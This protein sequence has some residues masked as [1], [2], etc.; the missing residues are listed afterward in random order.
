M[1]MSTRGRRLPR[2]GLALADLSTDLWVARSVPPFLLSP[3]LVVVSDCHLRIFVRRCMEV[4]YMSVKG[5][6]G[7]RLATGHRRPAFVPQRR[8]EPN[9]Y[10]PLV[11]ALMAWAR[12]R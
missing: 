2:K 6:P 5:L 9:E 8:S 12:S 3:F 4:G 1:N 7:A 10:I 11:Y